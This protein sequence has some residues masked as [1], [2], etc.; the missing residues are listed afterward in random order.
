MRVK[1]TT[2]LISNMPRHR[3]GFSEAGGVMDKATGVISIQMVA[4]SIVRV[5]DAHPSTGLDRTLHPD[6]SL[7]SELYGTMIFNHQNT[8]DESAID[9]ATRATLDRWRG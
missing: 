6:A 5:C 4:N 1:K 7:L 2:F 8:V 9:D 3:R